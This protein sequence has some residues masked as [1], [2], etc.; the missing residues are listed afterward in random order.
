MSPLQS[1][2]AFAKETETSL[3][4]CQALALPPK[5][6]Y[7]FQFFVGFGL[8]LLVLINQT[9]LGRCLRQNV[10]TCLCMHICLR[11]VSELACV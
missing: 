2:G 5:I 3:F 11:G 6:N 4:D 1:L 7:T 8:G 9:Q 10:M